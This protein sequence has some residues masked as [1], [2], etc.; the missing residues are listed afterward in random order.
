[1][2]TV[3]VRRDGEIRHFW[4]SELQKV[5]P[6]PGQTSGTS[7][8]LTFPTVALAG[9]VRGFLVTGSVGDGVLWFQH[10]L[11]LDDYG[12]GKTLSAADAW[13]LANVFSRAG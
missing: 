7:C 10:G 6:D 2:A 11:R 3:F 12:P 5:P 1:M 8:T 9:G 4:S 13:A